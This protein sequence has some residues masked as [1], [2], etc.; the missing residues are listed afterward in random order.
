MSRSESVARYTK[1]TM[2]YAAKQ[3]LEAVTGGWCNTGNQGC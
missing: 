2:Q 1:T 3:T